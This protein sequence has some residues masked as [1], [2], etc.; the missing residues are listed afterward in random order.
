M[1]YC[2]EN[3]PAPEEIM[4]DD[5][6]N[7]QNDFFN[8]VRRNRSVVAVFLANGKRLVGRVKAFDRFTI[9][10]EGQ[11]GEQMVFKHA[12]ST[13]S[14]A[15]QD[16]RGDDADVKGAREAVHGEARSR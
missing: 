10:L 12:I 7:L 2:R 16:A 8:A 14:L 11:Y 15:S 4:D 13:V 3:E 6:G 9:L 5:S 1:L